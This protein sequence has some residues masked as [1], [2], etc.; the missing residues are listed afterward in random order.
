MDQLKAITH[1][2]HRSQFS[3]SEAT[4]AD[5]TTSSEY[6]FVS[7]VSEVVGRRGRSP[8]V[9][10]DMGK[11]RSTVSIDLETSEPAVKHR[12]PDMTEIDDDLNMLDAAA[13]GPKKTEDDSHELTANVME[14]SFVSSTTATPIRDLD[15]LDLSTITS[16]EATPTIR[17]DS[18]NKIM[19]MDSKASVLSSL[20]VEVL[21]QEPPRIRAFGPPLHQDSG[22]HEL[23]HMDFQPSMLPASPTFGIENPAQASEVLDTQSKSSAVESSEFKIPTLEDPF[24]DRY[25][26]IPEARDILETPLVPL[27]PVVEAKTHSHHAAGETP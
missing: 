5:C 23:S 13:K 24:V 14:H 6:L 8:V 20:P 25:S 22:F 15:Q 7:S 16:C 10:S 19:L 3:T 18:K 12:E 1:D 17:Q 2:G 9:G 26:A 21:Q 4:I 11:R 27:V